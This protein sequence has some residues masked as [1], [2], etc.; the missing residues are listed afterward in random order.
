MRCELPEST[1]MTRL[2][3]SAE[4]ETQSKLLAAVMEGD[5][6]GVFEGTGSAVSVGRGVGELLEVGEAVGSSAVCED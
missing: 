1:E 5:E 4:E 6:V 2:K 3:R